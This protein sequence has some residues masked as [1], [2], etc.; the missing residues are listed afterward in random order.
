MNARIAW[1][2]AL[3]LAVRRDLQAALL[4][5]MCAGWYFA[6]IRPEQIR[7]DQ[8]VR[9]AAAA[10]RERPPLSVQD[11]A[12]SELARF[13]ANFPSQDA[14]PD[15]L[16]QLLKTAAQH[17]LSVHHGDYT[18]TRAPAGKLVRF[19]IVLPLR[20]S[21][22]QVRGF[23]DALAHDVPGMAL[24]NAQFE[25][26]EVGDPALDVKLRLVLFLVRAP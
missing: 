17:A 22:P 7:L 20:G 4:F 13:Y 16:E 18:V 14:F 2:P 15:A 9:H 23:L 5:A 1:K 12:A 3:R 24:E 8:A 11:P 25:R 26:R 19:Q 21:Y 6:A 10:Q